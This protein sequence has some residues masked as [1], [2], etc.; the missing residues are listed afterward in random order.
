MS[1]QMSTKLNKASPK[2][3]Q[4]A[5]GAKREHRITDVFVDDTGANMKFRKNADSWKPSHITQSLNA[6]CEQQINMSCTDLETIPMQSE[7]H[8]IESN[9]EKQIEMSAW[10]SSGHR[11]LLSQ[12]SKPSNE[13]QSYSAWH[14]CYD[15]TLSGLI[16]YADAFQGKSAK[17]GLPSSTSPAPATNQAFWPESSTHSR[18]FGSGMPGPVVAV[19]PSTWPPS[20]RRTAAEA[21][22]GYCPSRAPPTPYG[23][24]ASSPADGA[25]GSRAHASDSEK[26]SGVG[27]PGRRGAAAP[28]P[29]LPPAAAALGRLVADVRAEAAA[30]PPQPSFAAVAACSPYRPSEP[31]AVSVRPAAPQSRSA[32]GLGGSGP[33]A[34]RLPAAAPVASP[35][36]AIERQA[37]APASRPA[38]HAAPAAAALETGSAALSRSGVRETR[39]HAGPP[40]PASQGSGFGRAVPPPWASSFL[41]ENTSSRRSIDSERLGHKGALPGA[42]PAGH[43]QPTR[44]LLGRDPEHSD[45]VGRPWPARAEAAAGG[46]LACAAPW[47]A[48]HGAGRASSAPSVLAAGPPGLGLGGVAEHERCRSGLGDGS[49]RTREA[50]KR[51]AA[52]AARAAASAAGAVYSASTMPGR[53]GKRLAGGSESEGHFQPTI[54]GHVRDT[55]PVGSMDSDWPADSE[56]GARASSIGS[57]S[58][59]WGLRRLSSES[60][61]DQPGLAA[62]GPGP[63][64]GRQPPLADRGIGRDSGSGPADSDPFHDDY[65]F[66]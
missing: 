35:Q 36:R 66:W 19:V 32:V 48:F 7:R 16:S 4:Y 49:T 44:T 11:Q 3:Y 28:R 54:R 46:H 27:Y 34:G 50:V 53:A 8:C 62:P 64:V 33:P 65:P 41:L 24:E 29:C 59:L 38:R 58:G 5:E 2:M 13:A 15:H 61:N 12:Y 56:A 45:A 42:D 21:L 60:P 9:E 39:A 51:P 14:L 55:P 40:S 10:I 23:S 22:L 18:E 57:S 26:P 47:S 17:S 25:D 52:A 31:H 20:T 6:S 1:F 63:S 37:A 30:R 43:G